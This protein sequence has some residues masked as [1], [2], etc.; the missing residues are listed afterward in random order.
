VRRAVAGLLLVLLMGPALAG[1][2]PAH[3]DG[4]LG[5][6]FPAR[7]ASFAFAGIQRSEETGMGYSLSYR[8]A[9]GEVA[10]VYVYDLALAGIGTGPADPQVRTA[11][12]GALADLQQARE[13]GFYLSVGEDRA[14]SQAVSTA[15]GG[16]WRC[17]SLVVV[18]NPEY[19]DTAMGTARSEL[20]VT[21]LRGRFIKVRST[22]P[23]AAADG[24][25]A[26]VAFANALAAALG[27]P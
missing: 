26:T 15:T 17:A 9:G 14:R 18:M 24:E 5:V 19:V 3:A 23:L 4:E 2:E 1:A 25:A 7:L 6:A 20:L 11:F 22:H 12:D 21:A 10:D 16:R 27:L 13:L 8:G